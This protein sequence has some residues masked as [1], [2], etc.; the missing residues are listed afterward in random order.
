MQGNRNFLSNSE[1]VLQVEVFPDL[2]VHI[3]YVRLLTNESFAFSPSFTSAIPPNA[4]I[5][6]TLRSIKPIF[7]VRKSAD[8]TALSSL[9]HDFISGTIHSVIAP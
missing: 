9:E 6:R 7:T 1:G 3:I 2:M 8:K 5:S 4:V